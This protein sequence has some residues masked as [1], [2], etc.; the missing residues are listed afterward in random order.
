MDYVVWWQGE[1]GPCITRFDEACLMLS[2][3]AGWLG[4]GH[5]RVLEA[6]SRIWQVA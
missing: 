4:S 6:N 3:L 1:Q 2:Y 5:G